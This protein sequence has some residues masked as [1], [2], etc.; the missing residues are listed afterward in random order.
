MISNDE[1]LTIG[2]LVSPQGL[3]G[4]IRVQPFS[5]F[6]ERFTKTG[7]RWLQKKEQKEP[8]EIELLAGRQLPGKEIF[9]VRFK[10]INNR[11]EAEALIGAKLLVPASHRPKLAAN[12][13]HLLDL[14]GL[15]ARLHAEGPLIGTVT[16]LT[17]A[18]NDLLEIELLEGRKV[19][20]PLVHSIVPEIRLQE[21]WLLITPPPGLLEL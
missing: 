11:N 8:L 2:K 9:V 7:K 12:E 1:W 4:E 3:R 13:F 6:P 17:S 20:V 16:N 5:D 10:G 18:G 14:I 21:G 19:L 15:E